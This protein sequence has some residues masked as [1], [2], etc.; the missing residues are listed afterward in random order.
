MNGLKFKGLHS[1]TKFNLIML[2]PTRGLLPQANRFITKVPQFDGVVDFGGDT[3]NELV[4]R[5][6]FSYN[7]KNNMSEMRLKSRDIKGWLHNDGLT[8][9]LIFDDEPDRYYLAKV[10]NVL[11]LSQS[12][13]VGT[14]VVE[15][16]CNPPH[17][18][19]LTNEP[20]TAAD[21]QARLL[22]DTATYDG[23]QYI[24][25]FSSNGT[26][27]FTVAGTLPVKPVIKI[28]GY[29]MSLFLMVNGLQN[30]RYEPSVLYDCII[31]DCKNETVTQGSNG[32]NVF[33]NVTPTM[34]DYF[35]FQ[36]GQNSIGLTRIFGAFPYDTTIA[37]NLNPQGV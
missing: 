8:H 7:F 12:N 21:E 37:I 13:S 2:T 16:T 25:T 9:E 14:I 23:N 32:A 15:F 22:W 30:W 1:Y 3:Y 34:D 5:A 28:Y 20:V 31:I 6:S 11:D 33:V 26:M 36:P 17:P 35:V 18:Y 10:T 29:M 24:Q 27:R 19:L 4:I